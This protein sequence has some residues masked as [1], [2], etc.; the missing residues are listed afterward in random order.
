MKLRQ[1]LR[2]MIVQ[3]ASAA[4]RHE[5]EIRE[6]LRVKEV[7]FREIEGAF[8]ITLRPNL[9]RLGARGLGKEIPL[10]RDALSRGDATELP[11]G[12]WHVN[13]FDLDADDVLVESHSEEGWSVAQDDGLS[14]AL[15]LRLDEE[16][17]RE[18]EVLDLIHRLNTMRKDE[19]L[20]LTDRIRVTL[21]R[22]QEAL[23][24]HADWIARETL[25]TSVEAGDVD[26]PRVEKVT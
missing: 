25:A 13:G 14:V 23:L 24:E 1:P 10:I 17:E 3:G 2:R 18:G 21:P 22:A 15:D 8:E 26:E 9:P 6:E 16:L 12:G 5:D 19:G 7:E 4:T 20:E 11:N